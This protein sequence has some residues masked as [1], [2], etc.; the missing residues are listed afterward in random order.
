MIALLPLLLVVAPVAGDGKAVQRPVARLALASV[1]IINAERITPV[2]VEAEIR[3]PD[4]QVR[5]REDRAL[6]EFF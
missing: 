4:R 1:T 2:L 3:K 5:Q 6:V